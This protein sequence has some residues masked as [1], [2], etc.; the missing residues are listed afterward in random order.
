MTV[1]KLEFFEVVR[2][3]VGYAQ[4]GDCIYFS[5]DEG[6][7]HI[8]IVDGV[9]HGPAANKVANLAREELE[10]P[11]FDDLVVTVQRLHAKLEG[12][13]GAAVGLCRLE[14]PTGKLNYLGVGNTGARVL[15]ARDTQLVSLDGAVG[16]YMR[17]PKLFEITLQ[18]GDMLI[19]QTD[20]ISNQYSRDD[21]PK[22][23]IERA[24]TIAESLLKRFGK[25]HDDAACAV[26]KIK[27]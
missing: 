2:P 15:G 11:G 27:K 19:L 6:S 13:G 5:E 18:A 12:S 9:G 4:S 25:D 1:D 3:R 8:A 14:K 16:L 23:H 20:G 10:K 21:L 22:W 17:T 7:V 26:L 24:Q